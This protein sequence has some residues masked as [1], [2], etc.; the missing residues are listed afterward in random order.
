MANIQGFVFKIEVGRAGLVSVEIIHAD[1]SRGTYVIEDLDADPERFNE[2]L[3]KLAILRDAM[4][5]AEPVQ[6]EHVNGEAGRV[7]DRVA[8][9]SRDELEPVVKVVP[10]TGLV[11][12]VSVHAENGISGGEER[13]DIA[14]VILL[15]TDKPMYQPGQ[16]M[17]L[18]ARVLERLLSVPPEGVVGAL[19]VAEPLAE[20]G[21]HGLPHPR[22]QRGDHRHHQE[23]PQGNRHR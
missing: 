23:G 13:H 11:V 20:P 7:I 22:I 10:Y 8:R 1:G 6:I 14:K 16:T 5:R 2:R 15:T 4:N 3:S 18:G 17:H 21:Q 9:I 12:D 19:R